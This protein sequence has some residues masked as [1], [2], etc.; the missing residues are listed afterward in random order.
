MNLTVKKSNSLNVTKASYFGRGEVKQELVFTKFE[1]KEQR[2]PNVMILG[3][4]GHGQ[5]IQT[6]N[7]KGEL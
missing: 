3:K 1:I 2:E 5:M 7:E 4:P 6:S